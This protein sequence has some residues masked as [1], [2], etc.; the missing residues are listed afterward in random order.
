MKQQIKFFNTSGIYHN[1][2]KRQYDY[3]LIIQFNDIDQDLFSHNQYLIS[4]ILDENIEDDYDL[5]R[6]HES[7]IKKIE[8]EY[9]LPPFMEL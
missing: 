9:G 8:I 2:L 3:W 7:V 6:W 4:S 1:D 5:V